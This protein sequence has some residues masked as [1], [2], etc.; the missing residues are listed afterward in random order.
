[1]PPFLPSAPSWMLSHVLESIFILVTHFAYFLNMPHAATIIH[2]RRV[3]Y[4][5]TLANKERQCRFCDF[6]CVMLVIFHIRLFQQDFY[7]PVCS[8]VDIVEPLLLPTIKFYFFI[9]F[10]FHFFSLSSGIGSVKPSACQI[11]VIPVK[12]MLSGIFI[13]R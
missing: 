11:G 6:V 1:M 2:D 9:V 3:A 10:F 12:S 13:P 5:K 7:K 4:L 8:I